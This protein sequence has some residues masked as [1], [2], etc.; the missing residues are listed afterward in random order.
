MTTLMLWEEKGGS[1]GSN[2]GRGDNQEVMKKAKMSGGAQKKPPQRGLGVAQL[3]RLR[4]Q[5]QKKR[6]HEDTLMAAVSS[7]NRVSVM[8]PYLPS[9]GYG[10]PGAFSFL[11]HHHHHHHH[12]KQLSASSPNRSMFGLQQVGGSN[13]GRGLL[14]A[15]SAAQLAPSYSSV[16]QK[17]RFCLSEEQPFMA[18]A[19][20]VSSNSTNVVSNQHHLSEMYGD[21]E[22]GGRF[23]GLMSNNIYPYGGRPLHKEAK[24]PCN[25]VYDGQCD[26]KPPCGPFLQSV[27]VS[28][29]GVPLTVEQSK[30]LSSFQNFHDHS[31]WFDPAGIKNNPWSMEPRQKNA[32]NLT[33][34]LDLKLT[35]GENN[36]GTD[37]SNADRP[38]FLNLL[39]GRPSNILRRSGKGPAF[40]SEHL[41]SYQDFLAEN[42]NKEKSRKRQ[43]SEEDLHV[44]GSKHGADLLALKL[45]TT[46][47][48]APDSRGNSLAETDNNS[49]DTVCEI[50]GG[51]QGE[52]GEEKNDVDVRTLM[53][54]PALGAFE[55]DELT[56]RECP[57]LLEI[58]SNSASAAA[59]T[60][61]EVCHSSSA[62]D[63]SLKLA[64]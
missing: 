50:H 56:N 20:G 34:A 51:L 61:A 59:S 60:D 22:D 26:G 3:E 6:L 17:Y 55:K 2:P 49:D 62:L 13:H 33:S 28:K 45:S 12:P 5:E 57:S 46:S 44:M 15:D 36:V 39:S 54:M 8:Q 41:K 19:S 30:E 43:R 58:S 37:N 10:R 24:P 64:I 21:F 35:P 18:G 11:R 25:F 7:N 31:N 53:F 48:S 23:R 9:F 4:L 27:P 32:H 14:G 42:K 29:V 16:L 63:L 40:Y 47:A 1:G 52:I 38:G